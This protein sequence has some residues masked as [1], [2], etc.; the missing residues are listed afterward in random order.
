MF[1]DLQSDDGERVSLVG[2]AT[3]TDVH[4]RASEAAGC[5]PGAE[6]TSTNA[7]G[8]FEM[9]QPNDRAGWHP[10]PTGH[11]EHRYFDGAAW[12]DHVADAGRTSQD[13]VTA[14]SGGLWA[15][16][17]TY[18]FDA[19]EVPPW[20]VLD[21]R[22]ATVAWVHLPAG[23]TIGPKTYRLSDPVGRQLLAVTQQGGLRT[24]GLRVLDADDRDLGVVRLKGFTGLARL[25]LEI[26]TA[27]AVVA[28]M[29]ATVADLSDG[30]AT[31]A[32]QTGTE[33]CRLLLA[34]GDGQRWF[35]LRWSHSVADPLHAVLVG[36]VPAL[37]IELEERSAWNMLRDVEF[38]ALP[39]R[40]AWPG[41]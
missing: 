23:L 31:V 26:V 13:P 27:G 28:T 40:T 5:R 2:V 41:L 34:G 16:Q 36:L 19:P 14:P 24:G 38:L 20:P 17:L 12:T 6:V 21:D 15:P 39:D 35:G 7:E 10:D 9:S 1:A 4:L 22:G 30:A 29:D 11:H 18:V 33:L 25:R 37:H 32:D 8:G 3:G